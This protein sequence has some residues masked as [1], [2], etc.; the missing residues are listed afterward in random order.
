MRKMFAAILLV[1]MASIGLAADAGSWTGFVTDSGC[2]EK[3]AKAEHAS[4]AVK[5]VK[6]KGAKW[7]LW[8]PTSKQMYLLT[9]A[10]DAEKMAGKDVTVKG[11]LSADKKSIEVASMT[12]AAK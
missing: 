2:G 12:P 10:T 7:A 6:E 5:C 4:C 1:S 8:D 3:G 11:T 9:N